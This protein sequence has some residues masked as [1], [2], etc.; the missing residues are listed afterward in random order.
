MS[1][2][3]RA[4]APKKTARTNT[5][6]LRRKLENQVEVVLRVGRV[7]TIKSKIT[8]KYWKAGR[9]KRGSEC[10]FSHAGKQ[11]PRKA[12]PARSGSRSSRGSDKK[13]KRRKDK[14]GKRDKSGRRSGSEGSRK[15]KGSKGS[16]GSNRSSPRVTPA[17]VCLVASICLRRPLKDL[18]PGKVRNETLGC[19]FT[20]YL[21]ESTP[22][23]MSVGIK[24]M[25]EGYDF[26]WRAG[27]EPYFQKPDGVRIKLTVRDYVPYYN[28]F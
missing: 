15:S 14:R 1:H 11:K 10:E 8:C 26:V 22:P 6:L 3:T 27:K 7:K 13:D 9:C 20:P 28:G 18:P 23:V 4:V 21:L 19:N 12:T 24:C 2:G 25:D 17:A 16:W 5:R